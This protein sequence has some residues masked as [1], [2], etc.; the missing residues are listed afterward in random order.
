MPGTTTEAMDASK[1]KEPLPV[2]GWL[3]TA[4][5]S[6]RGPPTN[7]QRFSSGIVI[8]AEL[9]QNSSDSPSGHHQAPISMRELQICETSSAD[10][11]QWR[12]WVPLSLTSQCLPLYS[13]EVSRGNPVANSTGCSAK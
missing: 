13:S 6:F 11:E 8:N 7:V 2:D 12:N 4:S 1:T 9:S 3:E 5:R 10:A